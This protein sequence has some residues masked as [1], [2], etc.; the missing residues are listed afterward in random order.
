MERSGCN[1]NGRNVGGWINCVYA[2]MKKTVDVSYKSN[3]KSTMATKCSKITILGYGL[4]L[5][6]EGSSTL[7]STKLE[8]YQ[9]VMKFSFKSFT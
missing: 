7:V 3:N 5:G 9:D 2:C 4:A 1:C 8:E 6:T